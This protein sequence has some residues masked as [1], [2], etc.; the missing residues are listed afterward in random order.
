MSD[1]NKIMFANVERRI[2]ACEPQEAT[3]EWGI[4]EYNKGF[5]LILVVGHNKKQAATKVWISKKSKSCLILKQF[6]KQWSL[7]VNTK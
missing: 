5:N 4:I 6:S 1:I 3:K 7:F 2:H